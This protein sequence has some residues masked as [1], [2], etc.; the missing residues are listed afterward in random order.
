MSLV[1][2]KILLAITSIGVPIMIV[3]PK[4]DWLCYT[5]AAAVP[6]ALVS[7]YQFTRRA[8]EDQAARDIIRDAQA[9][10]RAS[11]GAGTGAQRR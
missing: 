2:S 4:P 6:P 11:Y 3:V 8:A 7:L 10:Q 5:F 1:V 9:C